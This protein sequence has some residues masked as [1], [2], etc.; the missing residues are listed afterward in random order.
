MKTKAETPYQFFLKHAGYSYDPKKET[1]IEGRRKC[2]RALAEAERKAYAKGFDFEWELDSMTSAE[3]LE[4]DED[5][6]KNRK[7]WN[8]WACV[9]RDNNGKV[10]G[11]LCGIDFG[12]NGEPWGDPYRRVVEAELALEAL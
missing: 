2:A 5:G 1:Q 7:P 9:A 6:G 12:R 10:I 3:W 11:S 4:D 8:T